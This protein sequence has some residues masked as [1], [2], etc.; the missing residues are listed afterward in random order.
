MARKQKYTH[1]LLQSIA[2]W[3]RDNNATWTEIGD[4]FDVSPGAI[5]QVMRKRGF[6]SA[7]PKLRGP[8]KNKTLGILP[9]PMEFSVPDAPASGKLKFMFVQ[10]EPSA[11]AELMG[12]IWQS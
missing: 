10:G 9:A 12:T 3:R 1:E 6:M 4:R 2:D 11:I 5:Q 7:K 8:R